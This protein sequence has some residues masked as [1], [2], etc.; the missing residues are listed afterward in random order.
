MPFNGDKPPLERR[1]DDGKH[2]RGFFLLKRVLWAGEEAKAIVRS[3]LPTS[4]LV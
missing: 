4:A 1:C 3:N 2:R